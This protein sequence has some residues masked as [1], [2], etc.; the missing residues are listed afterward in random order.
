MNIKQSVLAAAVTAALAMGVAGQATASVYAGSSLNLQGLSVVITDGGLPAP[1]PV[2]SF[3]FTAT[4]TATLNGVS[5][6][7]GT[8]GN[9]LLSGNC[10]G[11]ISSNNCGTAPVLDPGAANVGAPIRGNNDFSLWGVSANQYSNSDSVIYQAEL[12]N[13]L[14]THIQQI[15]ESELQGNGSA[16]SNAEITSNTGF[17]MTFTLAGSGGLKLD[18]EADPYLRTVINDLLFNNGNAQANINASFSLTSLS[19]DSVTWS[20][21]GTAANDCSV[22]A[23]LAGVTCTEDA[24]GGDTQDLNRNLSVSANPN[25]VAHSLGAGFTDFGINILGL[26]SGTYTLAFNALTSNSIRRVPE[27]GML[28]LLG[29]GLLGMVA[30]G[31]RKLRG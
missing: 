10:G 21:Q 13:F 27:P 30:A 24:V 6:I 2:T 23:G 16:N 4:N 3:Q 26:S 19:G 15:A 20:P 7:V 11:T 5:A 31:R 22:D 12:T 1:Q 18:F 9:G 14:P 25:D 17:T 8:G 28:A 29:I